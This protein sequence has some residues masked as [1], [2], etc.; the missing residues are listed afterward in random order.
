MLPL[1]TLASP[2]GSFA[3]INPDSKAVTW[4]PLPPK[5]LFIKLRLMNNSFL[6]TRSFAS[7]LGRGSAQPPPP[8]GAKGGPRR[9]G[10]K[11][12]GVRAA[13]L[14]NPWEQRRSLCSLRAEVSLGL[15]I[16]PEGIGGRGPRR[17]SAARSFGGCCSP[18]DTHVGLRRQRQGGFASCRKFLDKKSEEGR[19]RPLERFY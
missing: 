8:V 16:C 13:Q 17:G 6:S 11:G 2:S 4:G 9:G 10:P 18:S 12:K 15:L 5:P 14:P 19:S 7:A 3:P 1:N